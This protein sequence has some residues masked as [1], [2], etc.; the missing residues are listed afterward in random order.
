MFDTIEK[1]GQS[2][3]QH[4]PNN[5]RIYL[6]KLHKKDYPSIIRRLVE[7]AKEN[8]YSKIFAKVPT[9][10]KEQFSKNG[11]RQE[12]EIPRFYNGQTA[13]HFYAKYFSDDGR[14]TLSNEDK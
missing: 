2:L 8:G 7:M 3:I 10:A 13:A 5:Q 6:M 1:L 9:W 12:A 4:G 11:F 14:Q